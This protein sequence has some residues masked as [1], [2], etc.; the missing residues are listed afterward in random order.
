MTPPPYDGLMTQAYPVPT[1]LSPSRVDSFT[2]CPLAFRFAS[3]DKLPERPNIHATKGSLVHR[4]LELLFV[5]PPARRTVETALDALDRA[6]TEFQT[7]P[8]FTLLGLDEA[9]Q[10]AFFDEAEALVRN[11]FT[12]EDPRTIRE[13]GIELRLEVAVGNLRLRGI[14]D[15]LELDEDGELVVT[16]YKTGRP[17]RVQH[18]QGRLAGVHFYAYLCQQLFGR[19]PSRVQLMYLSTGET[20]VARPTEQSVAFLPK[21]TLA[22][23]GAV[24][25]AC[26]TGEFR[27]RSG[28]LCNYCA[29][30]RW[31]PAFGGDPDRAAEEAPAVFAGLVAAATDVVPGDTLATRIGD[32]RDD[33]AGTEAGAPDGATD[34]V[35]DQPVAV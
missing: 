23:Y 22:V 18:E 11:Y 28:A 29:F 8:E 3:I 25:R 15:R 1:S 14:I 17:P 26:A 21:R 32:A 16:D 20:I 33:L 34:A 30:Q 31:C 6:M 9:A 13:I 5:E 2:S 12:M 19:R 10:T 35:V 24:E 4:A 27:P 7:D